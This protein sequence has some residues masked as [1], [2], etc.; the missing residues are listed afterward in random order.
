MPHGERVAFFGD[1]G[2]LEI[3]L[4]KG[5]AG[6]GGGAAQLLGLHVTDVVRLELEAVARTVARA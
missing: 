6:A 1:S 2:Y 4:N 3:A 5:V